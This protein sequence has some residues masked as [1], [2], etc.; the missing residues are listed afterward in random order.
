M[1]NKLNTTWQFATPD[2]SIWENLPKLNTKSEFHVG[3]ILMHRP[4]RANHFPG[5]LMVTEVVQSPSGQNVGISLKMLHTASD[6]ETGLHQ[7]RFVRLSQNAGTIYAYR[8]YTP[9]EKPKVIE[10]VVVE[11]PLNLDEYKPTPNL[12]N[13]EIMLA[14]LERIES[15]LDY[16]LS[17]FGITG[18]L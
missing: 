14:H 8:K 16:L 1:S 18:G 13:A 12:T 7:N 11:V 17:E 4:T 10:S 9:T 6:S 5:I 15:K 2:Y 3:D